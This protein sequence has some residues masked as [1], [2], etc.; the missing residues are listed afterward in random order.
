MVYQEYHDH[1]MSL[2]KSEDYYINSTDQKEININYMTIYKS[3]CYLKK[4]HDS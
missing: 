3:I 2:P 1:I 4:S